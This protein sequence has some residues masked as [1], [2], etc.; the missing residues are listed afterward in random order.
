MLRFILR[1]ETYST[2]DELRTSDLFTVDAEVQALE[3]ALCAGGR[4]EAGFD[5]TELVGVEVLPKKAE[6]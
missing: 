5:R 3:D 6:V 2:V 1:R 4:G